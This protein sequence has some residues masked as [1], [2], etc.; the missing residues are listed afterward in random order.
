MRRNETPERVERENGADLPRT[1]LHIPFLAGR[2][3]RD[4][5]IGTDDLTNLVIAFYTTKTLEE[6]LD[7]T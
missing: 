7:V 1:E 2:P 5:A 3:R 4:T 6:F